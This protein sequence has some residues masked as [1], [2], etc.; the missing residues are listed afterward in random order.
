MI[1][2]LR[3]EKI[4]ILLNL[5]QS[6]HIKIHVGEECSQ[7]CKELMLI[8]ENGDEEECNHEAHNKQA[9]LQIK[10]F[11]QILLW[12]LEYSVPSIKIISHLCLKPYVINIHHKG[13][14]YAYIASK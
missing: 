7:S 12:L 6:L 3:T 5:P 1:G 10:L 13:T 9:F 8:Y 4:V 11:P 14:Y 2:C